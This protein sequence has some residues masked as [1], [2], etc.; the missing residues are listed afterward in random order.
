MASEDIE[1]LFP[2]LQ[3]TGYRIT[4]PLTR[5]YN[6]IAWAAGDA[7]RWWDPTRH[8]DFGYWPDDV[9]RELSVLAFVQ[10]YESLGYLVCDRHDLEEGL[11]KVA[12]FADESGRPTHA[13]RQLRSGVWTSKLGRLEDI[14]HDILE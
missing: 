2:N 5:Q 11:E 14:E 6:C 3:M 4:S 10:L 1:E 13:A 12:I 7:Q 8:K 9:P